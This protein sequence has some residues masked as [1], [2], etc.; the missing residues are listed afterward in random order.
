MIIMRN[1]LLL[2]SVAC[3]C[4]FVLPTYYKL[5]KRHVHGVTT[6]GL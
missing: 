1:K 4:N 6:S 3:V 5:I 2:F